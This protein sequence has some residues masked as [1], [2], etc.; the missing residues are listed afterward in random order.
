ME[1]QVTSRE[2][3]LKKVRQ[4]LNTKS[5][6][7]FQNIDLESIIFNRIPGDTLSEIFAKQFTAA[8]GQ[9]VLCDNQFVAI[10]KLL[11]LVEE[12][13]WKYV[14]CREEIMQ[15]VL[16]DTGF[17]YLHEDAHLDKIQAAVTGCEAL[18]ANTGSVLV[19]GTRNTRLMPI[20]PPVHIVLAYRSQV[21][22]EMRDA[23]QLLRNRYGKNIPGLLGIISGPSYTLGLPPERELEMPVETF[24]AQGPVEIILFLIDDRKAE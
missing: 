4:A 17:P 9:V 19:S 21:V 6:S 13:R 1:H 20:W 3:I 10:D 11:D 15:E 16:D 18:I 12:R 5:K 22:P 2:K 14:F 24:G 8:K 23:F 7:L